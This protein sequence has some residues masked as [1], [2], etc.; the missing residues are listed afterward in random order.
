MGNVDV[1]VYVTVCTHPFKYMKVM[2][3]VEEQRSLQ[4]VLIE[5]IRAAANGRLCMRPSTRLRVDK[6]AQQVNCRASPPLTKSFK[7]WIVIFC[8]HAQVTLEMLCVSVGVCKA[9]TQTC[10]RIHTHANVHTNTYP[11]THTYTLIYSIIFGYQS[12]FTA[13]RAARSY[14]M[15]PASLDKMP[16]SNANVHTHTHPHTHTYTLIL[17]Y[18]IRL[19]E[20]IHSS[21]CRALVS[22]VP[23]EP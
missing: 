9:L 1:H 16:N 10:A 21:A 2:C 13:V 20:L 11:H 17:Q 14:R 8:K 6:R 5:G 23:S 12:S 22:H 3:V 18:N 19:P 15:S 7:W 4:H